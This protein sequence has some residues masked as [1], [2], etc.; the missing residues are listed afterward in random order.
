MVLI[1]Q[2]AVGA[3]NTERYRKIETGTFLSNIRRRQINRDSLKR[4]KECAVS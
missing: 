3:Q 1:I 2:V 4:K